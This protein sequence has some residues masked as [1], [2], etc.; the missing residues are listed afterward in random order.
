MLGPQQAR[1]SL[2]VTLHKLGGVGEALLP[3]ETAPPEG[4]RLHTGCVVV[5]YAI[6]PAR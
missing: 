1:G 3:L 6:N 2:A 4:A 5:A